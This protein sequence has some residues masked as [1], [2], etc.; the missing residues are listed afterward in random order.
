MKIHSF[1]KEFKR[2]H[3]DRLQI[4]RF[5]REAINVKEVKWSDITP[6]NMAAVRDY[7]IERTASNSAAVYFAIIKA[8]VNQCC[9][10]LSC[11]ANTVTSVLKVHKTPSQNVYLTE[12][13]I[14]RIE[15]YCDELMKKEN[16]RAEKDVLNAFL[17]ECF[18]G[19][20]G[21]DVD[22]FTEKNIVDGYIVYVSKKTGV[23]SKVPIKRGMEKRL[24][25][26]PAKRYSATTKNR[27]LKRVAKK[28]GITQTVTLMYHG[29]LRSMPKYECIGMHSARRS[30]CSN[31]ARRGVDI[32]TIAALANHNQNI[33]MTQR[34]IVPDTDNL[35][36]EALAFFND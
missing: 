35:C 27:I 19:A 3:P 30:F 12:E 26:K 25:Y 34:Y 9:E 24:A 28:V 1:E 6:Y 2:R 20:R 21:I 22:S 4:L 8:L 16:H 10:M 33:T 7:I 14:S 36:E 5:M 18:C 23:L 31:L 32:Y 13:E 11:Q 29:Q 15:I 17:I